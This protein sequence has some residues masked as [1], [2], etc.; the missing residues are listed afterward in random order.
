MDAV[1]KREPEAQRARSSG[2][3]MCSQLPKR[4]ELRAWWKQDRQ[5]FSEIR[6]ALRLLQP[7]GA[8]EVAVLDL[9]LEVLDRLSVAV[10]TL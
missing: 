2:S 3:K 7:L 8:R 6:H 9:L 1:A 10:E 4:A 5:Y